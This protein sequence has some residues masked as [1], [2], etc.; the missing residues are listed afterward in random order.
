M[1][2]MIRVFFIDRFWFWIG[3]AQ[4]NGPSEGRTPPE[5]R[6]L[7]IFGSVRF[8]VMFLVVCPW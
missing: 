4:E 1:E 6:S 7:E 8:V 5:R 3:D 2:R